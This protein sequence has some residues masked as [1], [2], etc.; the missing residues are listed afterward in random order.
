MIHRRAYGDEVLPGIN[1]SSND[2]YAHA[3]VSTRWFNLHFRWV[4]ADR[5]LTVRAFRKFTIRRFGPWRRVRE[6]ESELRALE[7]ALGQAND[8]YDKIREANAQ[9]RE[10]LTLYRNA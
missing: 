6:L 10:T 5:R 8:R 9:L 1:L 4:K 2:Q 7:H 3:I